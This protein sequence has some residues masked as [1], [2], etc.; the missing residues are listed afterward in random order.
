MISMMYELKNVENT[1]K[2]YFITC[3]I[4]FLSINGLYYL[5]SGVSQALL[6]D[7]TVG[8]RSNFF[9]NSVTK[10]VPFIKLFKFISYLKIHAFSRK[11]MQYALCN[12]FSFDIIILYF[13]QN[14]ITLKQCSCL[15]SLTVNRRRQVSPE[16]SI[17]YGH[18]L[19]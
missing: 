10:D 6:R 18:S 17:A 1:L 4:T 5:K 2:D 12:L 11:L 9:E 19:P 15:E 16:P 3:D 13:E 7:D 14:F 8:L